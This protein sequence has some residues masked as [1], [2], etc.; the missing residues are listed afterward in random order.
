MPPVVDL[1]PDSSLADQSVPLVDQGTLLPDQ[2]VVVEAERQ[3]QL[4]EVLQK[5]ALGMAIEEVTSQQPYFTYTDAIACPTIPGVTCGF[6]RDQSTSDLS[7]FILVSPD[8]DKLTSLTQDWPLS[9]TENEWLDPK[10]G[11]RARLYES[12]DIHRI[13]L[14]PFVAVDQLIG[15]P[16]QG[17]SFETQTLMNMTQSDFLEAYNDQ[18]KTWKKGEIDQSP[19]LKKATGRLLVTRGKKGVIT[20]LAPPSDLSPLPI[21]IKPTFEEKI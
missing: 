18:I 14:T 16:S 11:L 1:S 4:P 7:S 15:G 2:E 8:L 21:V 6:L 5:L 13:E 3:I 10:N 12:D 17:F 9:E 20:L 19:D